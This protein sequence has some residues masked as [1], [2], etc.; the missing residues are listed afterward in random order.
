MYK[1]VGQEPAKVSEDKLIARMT[2]ELGK[3]RNELKDLRDKLKQLEE[4]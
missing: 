3:N 1:T 4:G 2:T